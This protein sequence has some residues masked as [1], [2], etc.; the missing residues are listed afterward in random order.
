MI[1]VF[2]RGI[3]RVRVHIEKFYNLGLYLLTHAKVRV[4]NG[5]GDENTACEW[6]RYLKYFVTCGKEIILL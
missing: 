4:G 3:S 2:D 6:H 1:Y 5:V